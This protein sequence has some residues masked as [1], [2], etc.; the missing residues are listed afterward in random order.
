MKNILAIL[1]ASCLLPLSAFAQFDFTIRNASQFFD[2]K[3]SVQN[4]GKNFC[5]GEASYAFFRKGAEKPFQVIKL[6]DTFL[7][8]D[9]TDEPSVVKSGAEE[10]EGAIHIVDYNFDGMEDV[11]LT[12][13]TGSY[14]MPAYQ[15]YLSSR[16]LHK[17][18]YSKEF[19]ELGYH[20]GLQTDT[21]R[22]ILTTFDKNGCCWH[23]TVEYS[24]VNNKPRKIAEYVE[25]ATIDDPTHVK[26]ITKKL[27]NGKW[28]TFFKLVPR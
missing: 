8:K 11:A 14:H 9:E 10:H 26:I 18:V 15:I 19:S 27:I 1:V 25:D 24:V 23:I 22:K 20:I 16:A 6:I 21:K 17:F 2:I 7:A 12:N 3:V 13:G 4:C 5:T 28:R